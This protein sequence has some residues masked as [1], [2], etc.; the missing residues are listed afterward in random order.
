[1]TPSARCLQMRGSA[2]SQITTALHCAGAG[3]CSPR[4]G[5]LAAGADGS[6]CT[7]RQHVHPGCP[8]QSPH[9]CWPAR[10]KEAAGPSAPSP[11]ELATAGGRWRTAG[12]ATQAEWMPAGHPCH[13]A[14]SSLGILDLSSA[15]HRARQHLVACLHPCVRNPA[16]CEPAAA[17]VQGLGP[18][19]MH[20]RS[21]SP[22]GRGPPPQ[23]RHH[24]SMPADFQQGPRSLTGM[25]QGEDVSP[26]V[27]Q[28][29]HH[30]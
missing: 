4:S 26:R 6:P 28:H 3:G 27:G 23:L 22:R 2:I 5:G 8:S 25:L 14:L 11:A 18:G 7:A 12:G 10:R 19:L 1:M 24:I 13:R 21:M 29:Q 16:G 17:S 15:L 30:R 20:Q 9:W